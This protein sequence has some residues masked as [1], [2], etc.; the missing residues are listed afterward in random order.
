MNQMI[1]NANNVRTQ[2]LLPSSTSSGIGDFLN[3]FVHVAFR[4]VSE[5]HCFVG[6]TEHS[7]VVLDA[8]EGAKIL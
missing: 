6:I 7:R 5:S 8:K 2:F 3:Q 4:I 1:A